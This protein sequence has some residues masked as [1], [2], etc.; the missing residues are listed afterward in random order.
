MKK[1]PGSMGQAIQNLSMSQLGPGSNINLK[2]IN[3]VLIKIIIE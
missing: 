3:N 2:L 1:G